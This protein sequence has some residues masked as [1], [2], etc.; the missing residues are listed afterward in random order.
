MPNSWMYDLQWP[1]SKHKSSPQSRVERDSIL[2]TVKATHLSP[3]ITK[4]TSDDRV[5]RRFPVA[6]KLCNFTILFVSRFYFRSKS[7]NCPFYII[8]RLQRRSLKKLIVYLQLCILVSSICC[9][10]VWHETL[11]S[12]QKVL[13]SNI[14]MH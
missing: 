5:K 12:T 2:I 11:Q 14:V 7:R 1:A 4:L 8:C 13:S 10:Q 6:K 3:I 9:H